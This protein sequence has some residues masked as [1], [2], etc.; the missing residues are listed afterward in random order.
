[1]MELLAKVLAV[2]RTLYCSV[3]ILASSTDSQCKTSF[4]YRQKDTSSD[5][6][7]LSEAENESL[8]SILR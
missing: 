8:K 3:K 1:M 7:V 5:S 2:L 6:E 4:F